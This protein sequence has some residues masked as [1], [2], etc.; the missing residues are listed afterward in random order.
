MQALL[1]CCDNTDALLP[2]ATYSLMLL[3]IM[4][5]LNISLYVSVAVGLHA[6][7]CVLCFMIQFD[8]QLPYD[9]NSIIFAQK[10]WSFQLL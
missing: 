9:R 8:S 2:P 4:H 1:P 6:F 10:N 3:W 7:I 5:H